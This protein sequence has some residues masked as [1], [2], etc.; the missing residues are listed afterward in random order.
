MPRDDG[1]AKEIERG[2]RGSAQQLM[3]LL[4]DIDAA[5]ERVVDS[6]QTGTDGR[7]KAGQARNLTRA[8][9]QIIEALAKLGANKVQG[10]LADDVVAQA[11]KIGS[12]VADDLL[13][14]NETTFEADA[15]RKIKAIV[16]KHNK[17]VAKI[18]GDA[19]RRLQR[20][21][22]AAEVGA[23]DVEKLK[24]KLKGQA[25]GAMSNAMTVIDTAVSSGARTAIVETVRD[26]VGE[27][28]EDVFVFKYTGPRDKLTRKFCQRHV[29]RYFSQEYI[30]STTNDNG[31]PMSSTCGGYNC[32]HSLA[33]ALM[34]ELTPAQ[35][36]SVK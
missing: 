30:D 15:S 25:R 22:N 28:G 16:S 7:I 32:R 11:E 19:G 12:L 36:K 35:R 8:R 24:K 6:L 1:W 31:L 9:K 21:I 20:E 26:V 2:A 17:D 14:D 5:I 4:K 27:D 3:A 29:K 10:M 34:S 13:G 33:P 23:L 18:F